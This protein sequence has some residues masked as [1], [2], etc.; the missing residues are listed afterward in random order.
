MSNIV[1][2]FAKNNDMN[3]LGSI[4]RC[5]NIIPKIIIENSVVYVELD[6]DNYD[7]IQG[8]L[9]IATKVPGGI[10]LENEKFAEDIGKCM[11]VKMG[12]FRVIVTLNKNKSKQD[13]FY[14]AFK[15]RII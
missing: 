12:D 3:I 1:Y 14:V 8:E 7:I 15:T 10:T 5:L 2:N 11:I 13:N 9:A 6:N 4:D